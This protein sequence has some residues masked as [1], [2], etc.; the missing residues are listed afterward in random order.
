MN[1]EDSPI[2]IYDIFSSTLTTFKAMESLKFGSQ[3]KILYESG[4]EK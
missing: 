3:I 4:I 2:P 1:G